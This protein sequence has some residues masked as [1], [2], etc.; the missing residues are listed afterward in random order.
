MALC[1]FTGA[2]GAADL[3]DVYRQ[4]VKADP[5]VR[6]AEDARLAEFEAKPQA[7]SLLLPFVAFTGEIDRNRDHIT[8]SSVGG[9]GTYN[10]NSS[11]LS[12]S[13]R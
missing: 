10:Y 11:V 1:C 4:A 13:L 8:E 6:A 3:L 2:A 9:E 5:V 12:L 7:R